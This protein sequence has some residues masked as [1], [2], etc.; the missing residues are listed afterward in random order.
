M[1]LRN[2]SAVIGILWE[3]AYV[4]VKFNTPTDKGVEASITKTMLGPSAGRLF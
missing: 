2:S 4:G 1:I 3:N